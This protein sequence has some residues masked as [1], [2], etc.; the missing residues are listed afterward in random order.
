M[1]KIIATIIF[2]FVSVM[3]L[4]A[5]IFAHVQTPPEKPEFYIYT[6]KS[7][8]YYDCE[9]PVVTVGL[10]APFYP[11]VVNLVMQLKGQAFEGD[12]FTGKMTFT[13]ATQMSLVFP[14]I[15]SFSRIYEQKYKVTASTSVDRKIVKHTKEFTVKPIP[16]F[17]VCKNP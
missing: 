9:K 15:P 6:D 17:F 11:K 8:Y 2:I 16:L 1:K 10:E 13:T 3:I 4:G 5:D 12:T 14:K 7:S